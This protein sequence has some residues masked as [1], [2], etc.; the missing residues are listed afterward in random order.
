MPS[1][2]KECASF[3]RSSLVEG[4]VPAEELPAFAA[5]ALSSE[6]D[7][8]EVHRAAAR[9]LPKMAARREREMRSWPRVT[10]CDRLDA[11]FEELNT[12]GIMARHDW[13][14]CG[15]CGR[16]AMEDEFDDLGGEWDGVPITGYVFYHMQ[17]TAE[18]AEG[19]GLYLCFGSCCEDE[20]DAVFE[21]ASLEVRVKVCDVLTGHGLAVEWDGTLESPLF[22]DMKW[23]RRNPPARFYDSEA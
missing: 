6:F 7:T 4:F 11:A 5:A 9:L 21:S 23:Q 20:N 10:D 8:N 15:T 12:L 13:T 22:V 16:T 2:A 18:A 17:A 3:L 1:L 19:H 14:C